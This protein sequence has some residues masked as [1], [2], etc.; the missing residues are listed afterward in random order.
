MIKRM[1]DEG[2]GGTCIRVNR[3]REDNKKEQLNTVRE[4]RE[5]GKGKNNGEKEGNNN[6]TGRK[7]RRFGY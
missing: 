3:A 6:C 2:K 1:Q 4:I 5:L 7:R